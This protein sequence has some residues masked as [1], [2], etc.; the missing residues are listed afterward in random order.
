VAAVRPGRRGELQETCIAALG[1]GVMD[2][3]DFI[4]V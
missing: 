1:N 4:G 2:I 3:A